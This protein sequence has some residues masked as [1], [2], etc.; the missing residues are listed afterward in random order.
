MG[1]WGAVYMELLGALNVAKV[2]EMENLFSLA[3]TEQ[4]EFICVFE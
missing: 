2:M 3:A 4:N 1:E